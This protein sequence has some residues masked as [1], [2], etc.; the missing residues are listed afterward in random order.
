MGVR[1]EGSGRGG[2]GSGLGGSA[3]SWSGLHYVGKGWSYSSSTSTLGVGVMNKQLDKCL[4]MVETLTE[5]GMFLPRRVDQ[6][7]GVES[8]E[9]GR[10]REIFWP[11]GTRVTFFFQ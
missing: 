6:C 4:L 3:P 10:E 11:C 9:P 2:V 5:P 8:Q 1:V 7:W